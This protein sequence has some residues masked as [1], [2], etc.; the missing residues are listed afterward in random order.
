MVKMNTTKMTNILG[1]NGK[2]YS[3]AK[4]RKNDY[5]EYVVKVFVNGIYDESMTYYTNDKEDAIMTRQAMM[6]EIL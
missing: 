2:L 4:I 5:G 6:N 3:F 1:K